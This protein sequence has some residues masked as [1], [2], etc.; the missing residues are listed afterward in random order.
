MRWDELLTIRQTPPIDTSCGR[1]GF[2]QR[3]GEDACPRDMG[4]WGFWHRV[5]G[6]IR[7]DKGFDGIAIAPRTRQNPTHNTQTQWTK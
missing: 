3:S 7:L 5:G 6:H 1:R 2:L 4:E